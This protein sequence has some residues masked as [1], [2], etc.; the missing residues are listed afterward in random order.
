MDLMSLAQLLGNFG[1]F[2]G[3]F[4][5]VATLAYLAIQTRSAKEVALAQAQR[6]FV[7][8]LNSVWSRLEQDRELL[9]LVRIGMNDWRDLKKNEKAAVHALYSQLFANYSAVVGQQNLE[10][11]E[12]FV[13][14]WEDVL[15][16]ILLCPGGKAWWEEAQYLYDPPLVAHLNTRLEAS[17][18]LPPSWVEGLTFWTTEDADFAKQ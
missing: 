14:V 15:L 11:I 16:G 17:A 1:E 4:A 7:V 2:L 10:G 3:L 5:V 8:G 12:D 18:D 6:E 9:R 13:K